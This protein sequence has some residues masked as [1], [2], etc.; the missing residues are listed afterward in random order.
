MEEKTL[1]T[2]GYMSHLQAQNSHTFDKYI[3]FDEG[4]HTYAVDTYPNFFI[5]GTTIV[6]HYLPPFDTVQVIN[7][8]LRGK[9]HKTDPT[10]EYYGKTGDE[11]K[12]MWKQASDSGTKM[13]LNIEYCL[14]KL[15]VSNDSIEYKMFC[16]YANDYK[17]HDYIYRTEWMIYSP[18]HQIAGSI[19][20]ILKNPDGT[21][22]I[23]DWKR[24]KEI[25]YK[26]FN[27]E[28]LLEP[29][30]H[31]MNCNYYHY[32]FQLNLYRAIL[33][34][35]YGLVV[36]GIYLVVC[37]PNNPD[38]KYMKIDLPILDKEMDMLLQMRID[39]LKE[40]GTYQVGTLEKFIEEQQKLV[41]TDQQDK[42]DVV[43]EVSVVSEEVSANAEA[44]TKEKSTQHT[45]N[46]FCKEHR[47]KVKE[48]NPDKNGKEITKLL[49]VL[50]AD[51]KMKNI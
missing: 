1:R 4:P 40:N 43:D 35:V 11:I 23:V 51:Y 37:H 2:D 8:I 26:S 17:V 14:N 28:K 36:S 41:S 3:H 15:P 19:D 10:Y 33:Q 27:N 34:R 30:N 6:H 5:S 7:N 25:R 47:N 46:S 24:S 49:G 22:T 42:M 44:D 45:W 38:G 20:A 12:M 9:R 32:S 16:D 48:E 13:H 31:L 50:W 18:E 39:E 29:F 21:Y